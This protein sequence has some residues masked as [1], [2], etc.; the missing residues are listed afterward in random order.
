MKRPPILLSLFCVI[1]LLSGCGGS[2]KNPVSFSKDVQPILAENCVSCHNSEGEGFK[3]SGLNL[4]SYEMLMKG[5]KFG[6]VVIPGEPLSSS[7][8]LLIDG[9]ADPAITM[10]HGSLQLIP[11]NKRDVIKTWIAQGAKDN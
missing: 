3:K 2:D 1:N 4:E 9:K 8:V 6:P 7:L 10:P 5:T 11:K